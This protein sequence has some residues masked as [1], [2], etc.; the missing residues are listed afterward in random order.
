MEQDDIYKVGMESE[1][2]LKKK[3]SLVESAKR[4]LKKTTGKLMRRYVERKTVAGG[5]VGKL[6]KIVALVS[7][8]HRFLS[9]KLFQSGVQ[10]K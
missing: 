6:V 10:R 2:Q 8:L 7:F 9:A 5:L 1:H 4:L 3:F